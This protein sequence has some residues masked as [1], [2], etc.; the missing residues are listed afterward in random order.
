MRHHRVTS[1]DVHARSSTSCP[2][3]GSRRGHVGRRRRARPRR[4]RRRLVRGCPSASRPGG[5]LVVVALV[6]GLPLGWYL[7]SPLFIR[8]DARRAGARSWPPRRRPTPTAAPSASPSPTACRRAAR[9]HRRRRPGPDPDRDTVR[10]SRRRDGDVPRHRRLPLR[11]GDRDDHRDR[12][13]ARTTSGSRTS[14]SATARTCTSTSR[15]GR[16]LRRTARSSSGKL[17]ATDGS[18][19]YDLP[20][21]TDPADFA[22]AIIWCKQFSHLFATA[23]FADG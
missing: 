16:R 23:P 19:G 13:R 12:A 2:R 9:R 8:T 3:T 14:R 22:S 1:T 15:L 5:V 10:R 20:A 7:A 21:G 4:R 18:F 6:V 17:K 11:Q